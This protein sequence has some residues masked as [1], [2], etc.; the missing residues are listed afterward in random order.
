MNNRPSPALKTPT[1]G[2]K[3]TIQDATVIDI[4]GSPKTN[5]SSNHL[6][7]I[8][9]DIRNLEGTPEM[10]HKR[11]ASESVMPSET[12]RSSKRRYSLDLGPTT[13]IDY[14]AVAA[15]NE[16]KR[17]AS[18]RVFKIMLIFIILVI[19][20]LISGLM[21]GWELGYFNKQDGFSAPVFY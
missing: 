21:I 2:E 10:R 19:I 16:K 18:E 5:T 20:G 9:L 17:Q 4:E 7:P 14:A 6:E 1:V 8:E 3:D 13:G 12:R 11:S 15:E